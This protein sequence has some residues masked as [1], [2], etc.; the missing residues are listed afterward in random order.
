VTAREWSAGAVGKTVWTRTA[1]SRADLL[2]LAVSLDGPDLARLA[3]GLGYR[4]VEQSQPPSHRVSEPTREQARTE[5]VPSVT[6][7]D[8]RRAYRLTERHLL[9]PP[10]RETSPPTPHRLDAES[11]EPE[12]LPPAPPLVP[13]SRLWPLLRAALSEL[14]ERQRVDVPRLVAAQARLRPLRRLPRRKAARWAPVGQLIIDLSPRLYPFWGDFAAIKALAPRLRGRTGLAILGM[15]QGP[16]GALRAWDGED[17]GALRA[18]R[19][20]TADVPMLILGD[21]GCLGTAAEREG[22]VRL[23]RQLRAR[24]RQAVVLTPCPPRWWAPALAGGYFPVVLDRAAHIPTHPVGACP[25]PAQAVEPHEAIRKDPGASRLLALLDASLAISPALLRHLRHWLPAGEVDVGSEAAAWQ[26][27]AR[28]A[29]AFA[30]LPGT[31]AA[32]EQLQRSVSSTLDARA[33]QYAWNLIQA[34]QTAQGASRAVRM[35]ERIRQAAIL[36]ETDRTAEAFQDEVAAALETVRSQENRDQER[37]LTGWVGRVGARMTPSAWGLSPRSE[38]LW[39]LANPEATTDGAALPSGF[40]IH[41]ALAGQRQSAQV[42]VWRIVQRGDYLEFE[43]EATSEPTFLSGSLVAGRLFTRESVAQVRE[44]RPDSTAF[45]LPLYERASLPLNENGWRIQTEH[46]ELVITAFRLPD[47]AHS[48]GRDRDGL[49]VGFDDGQGDRRAY[50]C[51]PEH[52]HPEWLK[53]RGQPP[54]IDLAMADLCIQPGFFIDQEQ[55]QR[56]RD[57]GFHPAALSCSITIAGPGVGLDHPDQPDTSDTDRFDCFLIH[58]SRDKPE[59]RALARILRERGVFVW[60]DEERLQPGGSWQTSLESGIRASR[61]VAVLVGADGLGP[62]EAE[63]MRSALSLAAQ[64]AKPVIPVLLTNASAAPDLPLLLRDRKWVDLRLQDSRSKRFAIEGLIWGITGRRPDQARPDVSLDVLTTGRHGRKAQGDDRCLGIRAEILIKGIPIA[65]RWIWPGE[66]LMGS[67]AD[68]E[69]RLDNE[70]EH[71]VILTR[72]FWLAETACTQALWKAVMSENPSY[73]KGAEHPVENVSWEDIRDFLARLNV[74]LA[75]AQAADR[76]PNDDPPAVPMDLD[77]D[78]SN[79]QDAEH[80]VLRFRLPTEAEWE[81][82]CRAGTTRAYSFG[83]VFDAKRANTGSSTVP[84]RSLPPN[85]WGLYEMHGN[86]WEWCQDCYGDYP[87]SPV[88]DPVG[89]TTG[90]A[91]VLRGGGWFNVARALRSASRR[92]G[93]SGYRSHF[94]GF[95]LALGPELRQAGPSK[96]AGSETGQSA[97]GASRSE[98]KARAVRSREAS[99]GKKA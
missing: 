69:G 53:G 62:W 56:F 94:F 40:D 83:D 13:W 39:L 99:G 48:L 82:A 42:D 24:G 19:A 98:R 17:W 47:W 68:E 80:A 2:R 77:S 15:E 75:A 59:V 79:A 1:L 52:A 31:P 8:Q 30:L 71:P 46:E 34:Q 54:S 22:W 29:G 96:P 49:F 90:E 45:S 89:P 84:V 36:G 21:L 61:S 72:G 6:T 41:R 37:F 5:P 16:E 57:E 27:P 26:H 67:T 76:S 91:R 73:N 20:A 35:E 86:V 10:E 12:P 93:V 50:W 33:R 87:E 65:L 32:S 92:H 78:A 51:G 28:Q 38:A 70:R 23:G 85:P 44:N 58:N 14:A 88:V 81:Y 64:D 97:Q 60:L 9:T 18:Y 74:E 7:I 11:G 25:W 55:F 3:E 4:R 95:R 43:L 63:E 66:F